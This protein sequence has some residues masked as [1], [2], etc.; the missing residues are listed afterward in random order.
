MKVLM[1]NS[2][3][4]VRSTGRIC[5]DLANVLEAEGDEAKIAYGRASPPPALQ[6]YAVRIGRPGDVCLH[7]AAA[8]LS[9]SAGFGSRQATL[10]LIRQIES[11]DPDVIHL[12]NLHGYYLHVGVLFDYLKRC[13]RR[14]VWTLHD[15]WAFTGHCAHF[16][17]A[18]CDRWLDGCGRCPQ[19]R[20]Y[21]ASLIDRSAENWLRKRDCFTAVPG[22]TLVTPSDWLKGLVERSF[23]G[24]YPVRVIPN[25]VD[26]DTFRF[27]PSDFRERQGIG[28]QKIVLG[29]ATAWSASK[30]MDELLRLAEQLGEEYRLVLVGLTDRQISRLPAGVLGLPRTDSATQLAEIY[31]AA[32]VFVN[33]GREETMGMTTVEAMA[34]GTPVVVSALTAVPETVRDCGGLIVPQPTAE[35][36]AAAVR[37]IPQLRLDPRKNAEA[38]E[39]TGQYRRYIRLYREE[40]DGS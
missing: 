25:G 31:S 8:R 30:G 18:H 14:I 15:C 39:K 38:F 1:I 37:R 16:T 3:C 20:R 29:C 10:R 13:G 23:L 4:G 27:R 34:C 6:R 17:A 9:D 12:H 22:M 26:L 7:G 36:L 2:V 40:E 32:D 21:P 19:V 35:Q 5:T 24:Q 11:Y 28:N 33:A